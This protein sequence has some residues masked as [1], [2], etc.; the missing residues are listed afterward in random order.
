MPVLILKLVLILFLGFI[1]LT[2][3]RAYFYQ[4]KKI[5]MEKLP[6]ENVDADRVAENLTRAIQI[7]TI[8]YPNDDDV[9]WAEFEK[10]HDFL[11]EAYPLVK[12][13]LT[14]EK[15]DKA[16]LLYRWEGEDSSLDALGLLSHID[17][18]PV[19]E[20]TEDDWTHPAF[21]GHN[22]GEFIW[23]RGAL[24]MKNHLVCVMEAIEALLAEGFKPKRDI[25]LCFG[26][27][28]EV[29]GA[30]RAGAKS[31][32]ETLRDRGVRL[33][34][35]L[36][37]GGAILPVEVKGVID[38]KLAGI[39]I[40]EKGYAD[41]KISIN[42]KG[43]HSSQPPNH[44]GLG[45]LAKVIQRLEN[46]QFKATL[47]KFVTDLFDRIGRNVSYPVRIVTCNLWMMRPLIKA[48]MKRIPP[49][50]S[51]IRTT[52]AVTMAQGSPAANVLPQNAN[53]TVNFRHMPGSTLKDVERHI[54]KVAK[55]KN[56]ELELLQG[57]D[58]SKF[59]PTDSRGFKAIEKLCIQADPD[60]IVAPF[61]VMGGTDAYFYEPICDNI[62]RFAPFTVNTQ[63]LLCTHATDERIPVKVLADG[64]TFFKRFTRE[65]AG[66]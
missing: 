24:D 25:Y 32:M 40:A 15:V 23:G 56:I 57:K 54:R 10:F 58:P 45:K 60:N 13:H 64:V 41:F 17:V 62:Y 33:E 53:V 14:R 27:N 26:H 20:G 9:D 55:N 44:T 29:V 47:P 2:L 49:A 3:I 4:P 5:Q 66:K 46:N 1:G 28:E 22:D 63:L 38:K 18:V 50:A 52:T 43:G 34:C 21:E 16:S 19:S 11:D 59:S 12:E 36:D 31:I 39:G 37:E 42:E 51:L 8:S 7:K 61:L 35:V 30:D 6:D 65:M 48:I